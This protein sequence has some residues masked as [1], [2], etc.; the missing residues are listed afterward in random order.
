MDSC[1]QGGGTTVSHC[2]YLLIVCIF[3]RRIIVKRFSDD[4]LT[5]SYAYHFAV[6]NT[7]YGDRWRWE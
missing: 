2:L 1:H 6:G 3:A 5:L 7:G 4:Q